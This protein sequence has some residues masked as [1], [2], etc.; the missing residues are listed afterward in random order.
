[1]MYLAPLLGCRAPGV[2]AI[3]GQRLFGAIIFNLGTVLAGVAPTPGE[4]LHLLPHTLGQEP[5]LSPSPPVPPKTSY[6]QAVDWWALRL[7]HMFKYLTDP[8]LFA[9]HNGYY[10]PYLQQNWMMTVDQLFRRIASINLS[11]RDVNAQLVLMFSALDVLGD[12]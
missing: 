3:N 5:P 4:L 7:N 1:D 11:H 8:T 9:D 2:W 6:A 10:L 12:R